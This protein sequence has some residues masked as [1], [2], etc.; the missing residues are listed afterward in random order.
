MFIIGISGERLWS[1]LKQIVTGRFNGCVIP[2]MMNIGIGSYLG[3]WLWTG[4][5][6][7]VDVV[8]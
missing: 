5:E 6:P 8:Q 1:E 4:I 7:D 2:V 3:K